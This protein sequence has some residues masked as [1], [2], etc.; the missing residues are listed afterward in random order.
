M[1]LFF[2]SQQSTLAKERICVIK[3]GQK[4]LNTKSRSLAFNSIENYCYQIGQEFDRF[5][6]AIPD[7]PIFACCKSKKF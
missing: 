1:L 6:D 2:L 4:N 5:G 3:Y 7:R